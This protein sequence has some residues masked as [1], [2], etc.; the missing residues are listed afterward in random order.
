MT[1]IGPEEFPTQGDEPV[2]ICPEDRWLPDCPYAFEHQKGHDKMIESM[3]NRIIEEAPAEKKVI[4][5]D[6]D[7]DVNQN[8]VAQRHID[9]NRH[10]FFVELTNLVNRYS[11]E[12]GSGTPD[13]LIADYMLNSLDSFNRMTKFRENWYGRAQDPKFGT[14]EGGLGGL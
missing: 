10:E 13:Y 2:C 9:R 4:H 3:K 1:T 12:N 6:K 14:P 7:D 11:M 8:D 5:L